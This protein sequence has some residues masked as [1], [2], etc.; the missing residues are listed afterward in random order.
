MLVEAISIVVEAISV[1]FVPDR[2]RGARRGVLA[3]E[4]GRPRAGG[5][6][7]PPYGSDASARR[8]ACASSQ[9]A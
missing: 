1:A 3:K 9:A 8:R 6:A 5:Y 4:P 2:A 7:R